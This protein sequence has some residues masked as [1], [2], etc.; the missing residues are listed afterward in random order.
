MLEQRYVILCPRKT[1]TGGPE[2]LHQLGAALIA[3][4]SADQDLADLQGIF[5]KAEEGSALQPNLT[6]ATTYD[7]ALSRFKLLLEA[8]CS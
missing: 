2:A 4:D 7:E 1:E 8:S 5:C 3:A 6:L